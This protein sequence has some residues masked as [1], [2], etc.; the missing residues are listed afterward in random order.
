VAVGVGVGGI[1]KAGEHPEMTISNMSTLGS[2]IIIFLVNLDV[3]GNSI[4]PTTSMICR[5]L[6]LHLSAKSLLV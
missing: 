3:C 4:S 1:S 2:A 5:Q 6:Q